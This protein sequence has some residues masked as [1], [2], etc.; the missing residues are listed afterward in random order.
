MSGYKKQEK[1][2]LKE[3]QG[4]QVSQSQKS[5]QRIK[6]VLSA[7]EQNFSFCDFPTVLLN[8]PS[9]EKSNIYL[10]NL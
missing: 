10:F 6:G 4:R 1:A 7:V 2:E 3:G 5:R 9:L 8:L